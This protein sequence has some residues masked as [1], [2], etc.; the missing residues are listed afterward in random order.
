MTDLPGLVPRPE[1]SRRL[2][3]LGMSAAF[4]AGC[5]TLGE[6]TPDSKE[7]SAFEPISRF[8]G[9][10]RGTGSGE[11]G[12][13]K[14]ERSYTS[15]MNG[16]FIEVR[17]RSVYAKQ[18]KNPNGEIHEDLGYISFDKTRKRFVLRQFHSEGFV[19][20]YVSATP[21]IDG[22]RLVFESEA[23][24]NIGA[25]F[26]ARE[27]YLFN[28][29]DAFEEIFE[30]AEPKRDFQVYSRNVLTRISTGLLP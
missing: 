19:N 29:P 30:T 23:I 25:G 1:L 4:A 14:V 21:V 27:T 8:L 20:Q 11:P 24:E 22:A 3:I 17:N 6:F 26:R 13:S 5:D 2:L 10:W 16:R 18:P 9:T 12:D 7:P 28:R 15:I